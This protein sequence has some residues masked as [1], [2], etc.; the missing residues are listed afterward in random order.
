MAAISLPQP[1]PGKS[2]LT[3]SCFDEESELAEVFQYCTNELASG[4]SLPVAMPSFLMRY[5][6]NIEF[7]IQFVFSSKIGSNAL[8]FN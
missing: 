5:L 7:L 2:C 6:H 1:E 4:V 8:A 3:D